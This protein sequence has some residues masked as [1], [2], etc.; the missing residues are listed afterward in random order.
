[1]F[2]IKNVRN[3]TVAKQAEI[4]A[5]PAKPLQALPRIPD[6][7]N[8]KRE[9]PSRKVGVGLPI[10]KASNHNGRLNIPK[11][12]IH[13]N[14]KAHSKEIVQGNEMIKSGLHYHHPELLPSPMSL[15]TAHKN[16]S[17]PPELSQIID[18]KL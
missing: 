6:R 3:A 18:R 15:E 12:K 10:T 1:M 2:R 7:V 13:L 8:R 9:E 5:S 11:G 14:S 4:S 17:L 16:E